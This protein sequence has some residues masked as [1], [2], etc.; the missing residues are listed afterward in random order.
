MEGNG[1][2]KPI[3]VLIVMDS[4]DDAALLV[5]A[6]QQGGYEPV[7]KIVET[8][9][10]MSDALDRQSWD[11]VIS[12]YSMPGFGGL[13][14]LKLLQHSD[15]DLSLI[16]LSGRI[17]E[18]AAVEAIKAGARDYI[19]KS[20][21]A[22][23]IPAVERE[24]SDTL[25]RR[26]NRQYEQDLRESRERYRLIVETANEGIW[27][28][29]ESDRT[30]FV[31]RRM[32]E[33]L[34]YTV[35]EMMGQVLFSFMDDEWKKVAEAN[36]QRRHQRIR[37][38]AEYKYL[39][40]D[41]TDLWAIVS[42]SPIFRD[43]GSY[44][45]TIG[46]HTD[47]T[48]HKR[49]E[50]ELVL[51]AQLLDSA[52]DSIVLHDFEGRFY[53][54]NE[55]A[56]RFYGYNKEEMMQKKMFELN[57]PESAKDRQLRI[58]ELKT[59]GRAMF[60]AVNSRKDGSRIP[61][62]VNASVLVVG[63]RQFV[64]SV[65]RDITERR[66]AEEELRLSE[67]KYRTVFENTGTAMMVVEEDMTISLINTETERLIDYS[68]EETEG[69]MK[70]TEFVAKDDLEEMEGY[71]RLR[72][73]DPDGAP[74]TY[75]YKFINKQ[76]AARD[77]SM[78]VSMIPGTRKSAAS[79]LDI[80]ERKQAEKKLRESEE[81]FRVL[82][83]GS[84]EAI[85]TLAPP[86]WKFTSANPATLKM[87]GAKDAAEFTALGPWDVSP[88]QQSDGCPSADRA[89]EMIETA[90]H[91]GSHFFEWTHR[92]L[93]GADFPAN[94]LL[95]R[96][97]IA[98]QAFLQATTRDITAQKQT[99]DALQ[100]NNEKLANWVGE[101]EERGREM[102]QLS[103]M[104]EMFQS[105]QNLEEAYAIGAQ[106]I[107]KLFPDD[108]GALCLINPSKDLVEAIEIWGDP[109]P[110]KQVF[111]PVDCWAL[112]R[113]RPYLVD[114]RH[115][116]IPCAHIN[117]SRAAK[118]LCVPLLAQGEALGIL[119]LQCSLQDQPGALCFDGHK[120]QLAESAA[121][122]LA[123]AMSS[124][125]LRERLHQQAIRDILT[126]VFNRRYM[127]E[128]LERE[129][130]RA[131]RNKSPVGV[132]MLDIDHFK[133]FNDLFGHAGGDALLHELGGMLNKSIRGADIASRY[134]GEEFLVVL[135]D[136]TLEIT[137]ERAEDLR[138]AAKEL[139][140]YYLDK[141]LVKITLSLGV[142]AFPEHGRTIEEILKSADTALYRAKK[143]GRD[144][145]VVAALT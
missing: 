70:W 112:R 30:V 144:R 129:L 26:K 55:I 18:D 135:S 23:L 62:E 82:F 145:V 131:E 71:H 57:T 43:D 31:N 9:A 85:M 136:A 98:G 96:V 6:L 93:D 65:A 97:E 80:T 76:G 75:E 108:A 128:T 115:Q 113:G 29:D 107:Q 94:V 106:Y 2:K 104:G 41:G 91:Q 73:I 121:E 58:N 12:D 51:R 78:I 141:P 103:E 92:R 13:D 124:L 49:S 67:E 33:M 110:T 89:K 39:R 52:N 95:T 8:P 56:C 101:L 7:Y 46:M 81:R 27:Q 123:L 120:Q 37:G 35:D 134:G 32:A 132:I 22:R 15:P 5:K 114:D 3:K 38:Q 139:Q 63:G 126:G 53:Y 28:I 16:L 20:N 137:R 118:Y 64:L 138:Q 17:G 36:I 21:L 60:E 61:V 25:I 47:I 84:Q 79:L 68:R 111:E 127:E 102:S 125:K 86:S 24:L 50:D 130:H 90:M 69:K 10:A 83:D 54:V 74:K 133:D 109:A 100:E 1:M 14:A 87:F 142:A 105:C 4:E 119:H 116:G 11:L 99:E 88:E 143:E 40:K 48:E 122:H 59:K 72:R 77:L 45:G 34:G 140:V 44:A 42:S 66:Q 19:L 117:R